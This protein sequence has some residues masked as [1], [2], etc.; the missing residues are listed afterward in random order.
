M[1]PHMSTF[2]GTSD[3]RVDGISTKIHLNS[4]TGRAI[5]LYQEH[6]IGKCMQSI[7]QNLSYYILAKVGY[8]GANREACSTVR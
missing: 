5:Q 2:A 1:H 4:T 8:Q 6:T 3:V 7:I